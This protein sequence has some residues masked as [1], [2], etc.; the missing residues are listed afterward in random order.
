VNVVYRG[1]E[2]TPGFEGG[3]QAG[4][5]PCDAGRGVTD[6]EDDDRY[7]VGHHENDDDYGGLLGRPGPFFVLSLENGSDP[8][9]T[10]DCRQ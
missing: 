1:E 9:L 3:E 2:H 7:Q 5:Q 4:G 10:T 6:C 8:P